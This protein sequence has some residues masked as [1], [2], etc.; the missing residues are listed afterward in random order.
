MGR[1]VG[2]VS[3]GRGPIPLMMAAGK[4]AAIM[5]LFSAQSS[6]SYW[7]SVLCCAGCPASTRQH[8]FLKICVCLALCRLPWQHT[9]FSEDL[10]LSEQLSS[11]GE[12]RSQRPHYRDMAVP[13]SPALGLVHSKCSVNLDSIENW[14]THPWAGSWSSPCFLQNFMLFLKLSVLKTLKHHIEGFF[15]FKHRP[16]ES[17]SGSHTSVLIWL[18]DKAGCWQ[19]HSWTFIYEMPC[20]NLGL[21]S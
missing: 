10:P 11:E 12:I 16:S 9:L 6:G 13:L 3:W 5:S 21:E 15:F 18:P 20:P 1:L 7:E 14:M 17:L 8:C 19:I 4:L 2:V